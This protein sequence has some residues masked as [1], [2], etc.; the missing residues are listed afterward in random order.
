VSEG[1]SERTRKKAKERGK[2][3]MYIPYRICLIAY[4]ESDD[5]N[6]IIFKFL[7]K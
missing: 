6:N 3:Q 1:E 4:R 2:E 7:I 5:I